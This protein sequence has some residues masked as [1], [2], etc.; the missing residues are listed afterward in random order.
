VII[1][2]IF[3]H[4]KCR[5]AINLGKIISLT[6]YYFR[7][8]VL[9]L[10]CTR[11][12]EPEYGIQE[13]A[14]GCWDTILYYY[15]LRNSDCIYACISHVAGYVVGYRLA[16]ELAP[17]TLKA[18]WSVVPIP[19]VLSCDKSDDRQV[20]DWLLDL[21]STYT[22]HDYTLQITITHRPVFSVMLLGNGF[23]RWTF[24]CFQT[25]VLAGLQPS[26]TNLILRL[27]ASAGTPFSC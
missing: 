20:L 11:D 1:L 16:C 8:Q 23:Q 6:Y 18:G 15:L 24:L 26:H 21:L 4:I 3:L 5:I 9:R 19:I 22:A 13:R 7:I 14:T 25:H 2:K 17:T 12:G 10:S 27:L